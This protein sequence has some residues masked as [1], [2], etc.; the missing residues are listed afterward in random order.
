[1]IFYKK[2]KKTETFSFQKKLSVANSTFYVLFVCFCFLFSKTKLISELKE[3]RVR[4][5]TGQHMLSILLM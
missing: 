4:L 3:G 5:V 2:K 1:M